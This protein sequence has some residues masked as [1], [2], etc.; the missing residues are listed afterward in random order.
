MSISKITLGLH[1]NSQLK[2]FSMEGVS[3][4]PT[5]RKLSIVSQPLL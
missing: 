5:E 4:C 2:F 1:L 3:V